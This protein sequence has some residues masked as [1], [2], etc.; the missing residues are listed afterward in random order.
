MFIRFGTWNSLVI[1]ISCLNGEVVKTGRLG[2]FPEQRDVV[3][4]KHFKSIK[5]K[6]HGK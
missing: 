3:A 5:T 1:L 2:C 6:V 4:L